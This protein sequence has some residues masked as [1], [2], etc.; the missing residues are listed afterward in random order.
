MKKRLQ[1]IVL[2]LV[3]VCLMAGC[4][5]RSYK[6]GMEELEKGNYKEAAEL[7]EKYVE[8]NEEAADA[9]RGLGMAY[10][11]QEDYEKA[12]D[13]FKNAVEA[14]CEKTGAIY[15]LMG[16][17]A[18]KLSKPEDALNYY[19]AGLKLEGNSK[20]AIQEMKFNSI[21]ACEQMKD[22]E[23]AKDRLASYM[24]DYPDDKDAEKEAEFLE[25]R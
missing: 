4:G 5:N 22:W 20:K 12:L 19:E 14:G 21:A 11:E 16:N 1:S 18:L 13:A 23:G 8:K 25:T 17:C 2:I 7:L 9:Y 24:E 10:W 3:L 15:H 6:Q